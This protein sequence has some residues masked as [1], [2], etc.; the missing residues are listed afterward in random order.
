NTAA[1]DAQRVEMCRLAAKGKKGI[2]VCRAAL[3]HPGTADDLLRRLKKRHPDC[4]FDLLPGSAGLAELKEKQAET[5]AALARFEDPADLD[6]AVLRYIAVNGLYTEDHLTRLRG[7]ISEK[8]L[9][10]TLGVRQSAVEL[11]ARFKGPVM[12]SAAAAL[13]HDCAKGMPDEVL[14]K[15]ADE[16]CPVAKEEGMHTF[17]VLHGPVGAY[18]AEEKFGIQDEDILNAITYHTVGRPGM[19]T[20]ELI[21]F[22]ADAIEPNREEYPPCRPSAR[23]RKRA[24]RK[25]PISA[26]AAPAII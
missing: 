4:V 2:K 11:A 26:S 17:P 21:I 7:M 13:L 20:L 24:W 16:H 8:R 15:T 23:R 6:P 12:K 9:R 1:D 14:L 10:H 18:L 25:P 19:T 5:R 3:S 22:V